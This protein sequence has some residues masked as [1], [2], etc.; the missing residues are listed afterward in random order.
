MEW[1]NEWHD[2]TRYNGD[3]QWTL[4]NDKPRLLYQL[5]LFFSLLDNKPQI[6]HLPANSSGHKLKVV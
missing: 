1:A 3:T 2:R 4:P 6:M 5:D